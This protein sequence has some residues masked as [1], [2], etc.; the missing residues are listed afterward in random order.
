[1][2]PHPDIH[3]EL[4][5][6]DT[7]ETRRTMDAMRERLVPVTQTVRGRFVGDGLFRVESVDSPR[8]RTPREG[9]ERN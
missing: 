9:L 8:P 2:K 7:P 4:T 5:D 6:A 1:M 3:D